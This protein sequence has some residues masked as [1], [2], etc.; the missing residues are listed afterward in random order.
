MKEKNCEWCNQFNDIQDIN[1][2]PHCGR[3]TGR[4]SEPILVHPNGNSFSIKFEHKSGSPV[5]I[6]CNISNAENIKFKDNNKEDDEIVVSKKNGQNHFYFCIEDTKKI[7]GYITFQY[8]NPNREPDKPWKREDIWIEEKYDLTEKKLL[9]N[10]EVELFE[11]P[12]QTTKNIQKNKLQIIFYLGTKRIAIRAYG[13]GLFS[14][15]DKKIVDID[16]IEGNSFPPTMLL[17]VK[18]GK[19][20]YFF[21][22]AE[23]RTKDK[24]FKKI[25][26]LK[27][28]LR[29]FND[30]YTN[31][32]KDWTNEYLL[33]ILFS[34]ISKRIKTCYYE[35]FKR[36]EEKVPTNFNEYFEK[37]E[38]VFSY[39]ILE[40]DEKTEK[41][42]NI[43]KKAFINSFGEKI[44]ESQI[45]FI[46]EPEAIFNYIKSKKDIISNLDNDELFAI[47]DAGAGTT[48]FS[49][50]RI[51]KTNEG[52]LSFS[53]IKT[54]TIDSNGK[55]FSGNLIDRELSK[56]LKTNAESIFKKSD[57]R[58]EKYK[59]YW[60]IRNKLNPEEKF[61]EIKI[62]K[63]VK[64]CLSEKKTAKLK[65][66]NDKVIEVNYKSYI[67]HIKK[68]ISHFL[69]PLSSEVNKKFSD[70]EI[71]KLE[72]IIMVGGSNLWKYMREYTLSKLHK[73][74]LLKDQILAKKYD[75]LLTPKD[76]LNA[77][78]EGAICK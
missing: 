76:R 20:K 30:K 47:V 13:K 52:E 38:Y 3:R 37:P 45:K 39:P 46:S 9:K 78:I 69:K 41:Y 58:E 2:C 19:G 12:S 72:N 17:D 75:N 31:D 43:F 63:Q 42:K 28:Y 24:K 22:E 74:G 6:K 14:T 15:L 48:D 33:S 57:K 5:N 70:T 7:K 40:S 16:E 10:N 50:G 32:N 36:K 21:R 73:F 51:K 55:H 77:V 64:E 71:K 61:N 4:I 60:E 11:S 67:N 62:S 1:F 53:E 59:N 54:I 56:I 18:T 49:I 68:I 35:L 44:E 23:N 34:E 66:E 26:N 65:L 25:E 29:D 27:T 8:N